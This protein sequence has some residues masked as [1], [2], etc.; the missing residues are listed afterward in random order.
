MVTVMLSYLL[1]AS[2]LAYF[3]GRMLGTSGFVQTLITLVLGV[4]ALWV[5]AQHI[6]RKSIISNEAVTKTVVSV[7]LFFLIFGGGALAFSTTLPTVS[8]SMIISSVISLV[9][10]MVAYGFA[11]YFFLRKAST[12]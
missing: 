1:V 9:L 4:G 6:Q 2:L 11:L 3:I 5:G 8:T 12:V 7:E 10:N